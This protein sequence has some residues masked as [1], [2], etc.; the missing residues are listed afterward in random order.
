[1]I[2]H[3]YLDKLRDN[4]REK[5]NSITGKRINWI[6]ANPYFY[7]QLIKTLQ[8]IIR[9]GSRVLHVRCSI[10]Y[11]LNR[12]DTSYGVGV[13]DSE[14][15]IAEAKSKYPHL[16]FYDQ[17]AEG[18]QLD[19][20]FDYILITTPEDIVDFKAVLDS[21][22]KCCTPSTRIVIIYYSILW[23]PLVKLAEKLNLR[24]PQKLH[25]WISS[26]DLNNLLV[27]SGYESFNHSRWILFPF[28]IPI[29]SYLLN[30]FV[31]RLPI[32]RHLT[33]MRAT[34]ARPL[35]ESTNEFSV[36]VVIP[37]RN[38]EGNIEDA[39][40]RIPQLGSHTEII[41]G[42]DKSTDGTVAKIKEMMVKY[43]E[44][45]IKLV[46]SPGICKAMNVWTCFDAATCDILMIL[47][48]DLT[49]I[50]EE[51][52]YFYEAIARGR[53]EFINGSRMMYPMH[54]EA[55]RFFN[56]IGNK[57]FSIAFSY[58]LDVS[59]KDTLCGTKVLFRKDFEHVK[60][61]RGSW[62]INDRWG[63]Y[64]LIFGASKSQ[65]KL[66]DL[67]VHYTERT[68]G[69]TK[70]TGRVKNGIIMLKMCWAA[71]FKIKFY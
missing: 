45:D 61:L 19:E 69:T 14:Q 63:D 30:R 49:V 64:E 7:N 15:Q 33:F 18:L 55:M 13:D 31:A 9:P 5:S 56:I 41:F 17:N 70:M 32:L 25:N 42:D 38:E 4:I 26:G 27:H 36:S 24:L 29:I 35:M 3:P 71:L 65:L 21:V 54:E 10:G 22:K 37:C 44:K 46:N 20:K 34:V 43:P 48:A 39:I 66:I 52:P 6:N 50:P 59:I 12:L 51:L 11:I 16:H 53:G 2:K 68:Y 23:Y 47:D 58:I 40:K 57:F 28:N 1:M 67:P 62:G 60:K 8:Y